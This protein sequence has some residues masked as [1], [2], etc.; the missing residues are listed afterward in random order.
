[1]KKTHMFYY[2]GWSINYGRLLHLGGNAY[3]KV[4]ISVSHFCSYAGLHLQ[5][6]KL[7]TGSKCIQVSSV[8]I[9]SHHF[10]ALG[11][12]FKDGC[13]CHEDGCK[14]HANKGLSKQNFCISGKFTIKQKQPPQFTTHMPIVVLHFIEKANKFMP[15]Q[16]FRKNYCRPKGLPSAK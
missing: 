7:R 16:P 14:C 5:I 10:V 12:G 11:K 3:K 4:Y 15:K 2:H 8:F 1:M 6:I 9:F 13:K